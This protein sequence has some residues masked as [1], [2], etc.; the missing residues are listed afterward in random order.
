MRVLNTIEIPH[1][2][3]YT[4]RPVINI[5][6]YSRIPWKDRGRDFR[7]CDC[8]GLVRLILREELGKEIPDF[9]YPTASDSKNADL[10]DLNKKTIE[11]QEVRVPQEGDI[12]LMKKNGIPNH[13]G[14]YIS[15]GFVLHSDKRMGVCCER[16]GTW[17]LR[18]RIEGF[19]RV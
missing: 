3:D 18:G 11:A 19:Y 6:K 9:F 17:N 13:M 7:G 1:F 10:I 14:V 16:V 2:R 4:G 5:E 15:G 12:V 8:Y